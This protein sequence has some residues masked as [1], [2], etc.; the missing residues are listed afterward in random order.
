MVLN[1]KDLNNNKISCMIKKLNIIFMF[2]KMIK[3]LN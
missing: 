3:F 1:E 2:S